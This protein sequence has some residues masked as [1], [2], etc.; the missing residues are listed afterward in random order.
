MSF[1]L[2][3]ALLVTIFYVCGKASQLLGSNLG[4]LSVA[5]ATVLGTGAYA[6][7][8]VA[9]DTGKTFAAATVAI[10]V[11]GAFGAALVG[12]SHRIH[13]NE[14]SL[15]TFAWQLVWFAAASNWR[16]VTGGALGFSDVKQLVA[17]S[18]DL[19]LIVYVVMTAAF[20]AT[21]HVLWRLAE[22]RPFLRACQIVVR[23]EELAATI[24]LPAARMRLQIGF[25][26][27]IVLGFAGVLLASYIA[28]VDPN[29]FA[30]STSMTIL[31]I[32]L[33]AGSQI[34][35]LG[36]LTGAALLVGVPESTRFIAAGFERAGFLQMAL[37]GSVGALFTYW[38]FRDD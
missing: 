35:W 19:S 27:G 7:A 31:A 6:Y 1:L 36:P 8:L 25:V 17:L 15:F 12:L 2:G 4:L 21:I 28:F 24:G 9:H 32:G 38:L 26:Y 16:S 33:F 11:A 37:A 18:G 30:I 29:Q 5:H 14:Y 22:R 10:V 13:G 23:S 3:I 20:G 34:R